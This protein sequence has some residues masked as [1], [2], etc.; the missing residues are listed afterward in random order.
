MMNK[1]STTLITSL[2]AGL[3][4]ATTAGAYDGHKGK[5]DSAERPSSI[6]RDA[7][8]EKSGAHFDKLDANSDGV[9]TLAEVEAAFADKS[10]RWA[11]ASKRH[12]AKMDV[13][14]EG[15]VTREAALAQAAARF[16][17]MDTDGNSELSREEMQAHRAA[18]K[19]KHAE[20]R[21]KREEGGKGKGK[22]KA[23]REG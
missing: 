13:N 4:M 8:V 15:Q 18:M 22:S 17:A 6:S 5:R 20:W 11:K 23:G 1:S 7:F 3:L 2:M 16:D 9:V 21:A 14:N 10:E 19:E 12:F